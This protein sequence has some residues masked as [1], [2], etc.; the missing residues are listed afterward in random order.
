MTAAPIASDDNR[1]ID[2][3]DLFLYV[4]A[5]AAIAWNGCRVL[6]TVDPNGSLTSV[7]R[8]I[9][10]AG[11]VVLIVIGIHVWRSH[12]CTTLHAIAI[13][14]IAG[15][16]FFARIYGFELLDPTNIGWVLRGDWGGHYG[17]WEMYRH[18]PWTWPLGSTPTLMY[19][20]GTSVVY[21]DSLPLVAMLLKPAS[22]VLPPSFQ[23]VGLWFAL[24]C[25]LQGAFGALLASARSKSL[26]A[27]FLAT[28]FFI[29]APVF[30]QRTHHIT[31]MS[32]WL[33]LAA[34]W[35]YFRAGPFRRLRAEAWPWWLLAA[36]AALTTPYFVAMIFAIHAAYWFRR[37]YIDRER[38]I[39]QWIIV[40]GVAIALTLLLW[41]ISGGLM[42]GFSS[43]A[44]AIPYGVFSFN[45]LG[46]FNP[47][48]FSRIFPK[49][50]IGS[51]QYEGFAYLGLGV[52]LLLAIAT[53]RALL[54]P[55]RNTWRTHWP[56]IV[57][58]IATALFA[59]SSVVLAGPHVLLDWPVDTPLLATFRSSGRFIWI[60]YYLIVLGALWAT[61]S[62]RRAHVSAMILFSAFALQAWELDLSHVSVARL[63]T[64]QG[65]PAAEVPLRDPRWDA[66]ADGRH[67]LT[68]I[69]PLMC[70]VQP[71]SSYLPFLL[72]AAK[73]SMTLNSGYVARWDAQAA[74]RYCD[75]LMDYL[76]KN[77]RSD[78]D[79]Y[80]VADDWLSRFTLHDRSARC[81][82][83]DN[84]RAC[85]FDTSESMR[86]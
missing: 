30:I 22:A 68:L 31:L 41:L 52:F 4:V 79:L 9:Q 65:L 63:R 28:N 64:G 46:F 84:L 25:M 17:G 6:H 51:G 19:P 77:K 13:G 69:P 66:L 8:T 78:D 1:R 70:G 26:S 11:A 20:L 10:I 12:R 43:G 16:T 58:A 53:T 5:C 24:C 21:T 62:I 29:F 33:L 18:A 7:D 67:H 2:V 82:Q 40:S 55:H 56:L 36:I 42:L 14:I 27:I 45:L 60:A 47:D 38:T 48:G 59:T 85:V 57:A 15:L 73:H 39:V 74:K 3:F 71:G 54:L 49:I 44:S 23:Y 86:P 83:L 72:L 37:V 61:L 80:V 81:E 76:A 32:H 35:L 75:Q 50:A 34:I